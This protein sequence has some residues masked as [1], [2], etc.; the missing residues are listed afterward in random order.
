MQ[1]ANFMQIFSIERSFKTVVEK[2]ERFSL[3]I[4]RLEPNKVVF[5]ASFYVSLSPPLE[6]SIKVSK[7]KRTIPEIRF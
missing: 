2:E 1:T 7:G 4:R 5:S 3:K 6:S